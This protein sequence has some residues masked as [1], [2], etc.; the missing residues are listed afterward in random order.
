MKF[1][2][3][4][5]L[6]QAIMAAKLT[7]SAVANRLKV[8]KATL[9]RW[10]SGDTEP[11]SEQQRAIHALFPQIPSR[12]RP[13]GEEA[14]QV[15]RE[16]ESSR[17]NELA[18]GNP[19]AEPAPVVVV[20]LVRTGTVNDQRRQGLQG[21]RDLIATL[22]ARMKSD[23]SASNLAPLGN[24]LRSLYRQE[25]EMLAALEDTEHGW[26]QSQSFRALADKICTALEP[27]PEA[28]K[29]VEDAFG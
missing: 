6:R 17:G 14:L 2:D 18:R 8:G 21:V 29:A 27:Y 24:T 19:K 25:A 15:D 26:A 20:P 16:S 22:E 23:P 11:R 9:S 5:K 1:E 13:N 7:E 28:S 10:C 4:P 3:G 12:W